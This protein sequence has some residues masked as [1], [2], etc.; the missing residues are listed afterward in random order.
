MEFL[1]YKMY[2]DIFEIN[3]TIR[4][5][6]EPIAKC[7]FLFFRSHHDFIKD[8][9]DGYILAAFLDMFNMEKLDSMPQAFPLFS[10]M[11]EDQKCDWL[12]KVA[13]QL[14]NELKIDETL[15]TTFETV[16]NEIKSY[17]VDHTNIKAMKEEEVYQCALCG[18]QY[19]KEG[20]LKKHLLKKHGWKFHD[21]SSVSPN[22][23]S[24]VQTFLVMSLLYRDT[25]N[26]YRMG[27][28]DRIVRNA[29]LEWI[30][31]AGL[32]HT[33]YKL[34]LFRLLCNI[35][36]LNPKQSFEYKWNMTVNLQGGIGQNIPND[37]LVEMQVQNI[38]SQLNA[39][40]SNKSFQSAKQICLTTQVTDA[41]KKGM[42][43]TT[44]TVTSKGKRPE[45]NKQSD[46]EAIVKC[47]RSKGLVKELN[48]PSFSK[49]TDPISTLKCNDLHA[50]ICHQ[51]CVAN[52]HLK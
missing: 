22:T 48:W 3:C 12:L 2:G 10:L 15:T 41:I 17:D 30:F 25:C 28:G 35:F 47:V 44:K 27:D 40:G 43:K 18:L 51:K 38:K 20:W 7:T 26:S 21:S 16:M 13:E 42:I 23:S 14:L 34:W 4:H 46:L 9:T 8:T 29:Y 50:W 6:C 33:K 5:T 36:I 19:R 49:F 45:V 52:I 39:Q 32:K 37:N 1:M 24:P 11:N 31:A